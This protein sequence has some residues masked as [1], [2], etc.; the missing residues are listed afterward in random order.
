MCPLPLPG[1]LT[2]RTAE[3]MAFKALVAATGQPQKARMESSKIGISCYGS[4]RSSHAM[5]D[6]PALWQLKL[7]RANSVRVGSRSEA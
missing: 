2:C 7:T 4:G 1:Q 6:A 3:R 5:K